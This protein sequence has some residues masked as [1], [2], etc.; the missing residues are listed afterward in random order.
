MEGA[1][2]VSTSFV[3]DVFGI[4]VDVIHRVGLGGDILFGSLGDSVV[5]GY[6]CH[7]DCFVM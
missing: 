7:G 5:L 1:Y 3:R 2:L 6:V 4:A